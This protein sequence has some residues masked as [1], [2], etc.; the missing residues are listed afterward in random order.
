[1]GSQGVLKNRM[2]SLTD[3]RLRRKTCLVVATLLTTLFPESRLGPGSDDRLAAA[4]SRETARPQTVRLRR[5][6]II[7]ISAQLSERVTRS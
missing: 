3:K 2:L 6:G 4:I 5:R 1:M 7:T